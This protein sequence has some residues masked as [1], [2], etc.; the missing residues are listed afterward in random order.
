MRRLSI[1]VFFA[2]LLLLTTTGCPSFST[3]QTAETA[4]EGET[5]IAAS[6]SLLRFGTTGTIPDET[7]EESTEST[8]FT[9]P[10]AEVGVRHGLT[11]DLDLGA[12]LYL[13]GTAFELKYAFINNPNFT[14]S[15]NPYVSVTG[16]GL[17]DQSGAYGF[18][19]LNVL[20]DVAK[21]DIMTLTLGLKPGVFY[22]TVGGQGGPTPVAGGMAGLDLALSDAFSVMPNIDIMLPLSNFDADSV[23]SLTLY[24]AGVA[25]NF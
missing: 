6:G 24:N 19:L 2:A 23:A 7:G 13:I 8:G 21:T 25:F 14:M 3:L 12:K 5:D 11:D 18:A 10:T 15:V 1:L 4:G 20:A 16:F 22:A 17:D 9:L